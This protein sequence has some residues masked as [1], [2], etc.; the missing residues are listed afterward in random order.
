[1]N[2]KPTWIPKESI[3]ENEKDVESETSAIENG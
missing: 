2:I 3:D 1:M